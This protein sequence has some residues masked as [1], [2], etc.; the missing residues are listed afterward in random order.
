MNALFPNGLA[1]GKG[2]VP[3]FTKFALRI[4]TAC[5][6]DDSPTLRTDRA[7]DPAVAIAVFV[8]RII[9]GAESIFAKSFVVIYPP[10]TSGVA[11]A[12]QVPPVSAGQPRFVSPVDVESA[13]ILKVAT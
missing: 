11:Q 3:C 7:L 4:N 5:M 1:V 2:A 9:P 6:V 13:A 12:V 8:D 10:P